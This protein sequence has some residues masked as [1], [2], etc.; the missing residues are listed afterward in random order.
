MIRH[1]MANVVR[2]EYVP[3]NHTDT[4]LVFDGG[5]SKI[6]LLGSALGTIK[7]NHDTYHESKYLE[8]CPDWLEDKL[9]KILP[10]IKAI[11][12]RF[13]KLIENSPANLYYD[14]ELDSCVENVIEGWCVNRKGI[15]VSN[16]VSSPS[17]SAK[18]P[19]RKPFPKAKDMNP[20]AFKV[21]EYFMRMQK[22]H[23]NWKIPEEIKLF[24]EKQE[25]LQILES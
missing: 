25:A 9:P 24:I 2:V 3:P 14:S 18:D 7:M 13:E 1:L 4:Y 23:V 17:L 8:D 6:D 12:I 16:F 10:F 11:Q 22:L 5:L 19:F 15:V 21:V 20:D